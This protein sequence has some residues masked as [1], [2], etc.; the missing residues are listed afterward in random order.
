MV[1]KWPLIFG[2]GH[3]KKK[4]SKRVS[5]PHLLCHPCERNTARR[6][7]AQ[8]DGHVVLSWKEISP[9]HSNKGM[10]HFKA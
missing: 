9:L 3:K 6:H 4:V 1:L 10:I 5:S 2:A 8:A 7:R